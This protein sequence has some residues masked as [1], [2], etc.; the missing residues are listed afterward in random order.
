MRTTLLPALREEFYRLP[1][2][3]GVFVPD[4]LVFRGAPALDDEEGQGKRGKGGID[5]DVGGVKEFRDLCREERFYVDVVSAGMLRFPEVEERV[6]DNG[7]LE[8][9]YADRKD[10]E[11]VE[12]KMRAV[13]RIF[14]AKGVEKV[15][16]GAWGCGAYGNPVGEVSRAWKKV[17][18]AG[19]RKRKS[20]DRENWHGIKEVVFAVRDRRMAEDFAA[21]WGDGLMVE[22]EAVR[23]GFKG[24]EEN[25][26][27]TSATKELEIKIEEVEAQMELAKT[28]ILRASLETVLKEL[29]DQL[30]Q[31]QA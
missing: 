28:P 9:V 18:L 2:V 14:E 31:V 10:L 23:N 29:K 5:G 12:R 7:R 26:E 20:G 30:V 19:E 25:D 3:G 15:V 17:L 27:C 11:V 16:L 21:C 13:M 22:D 1:E 24:T 6:R 4:V 8:T